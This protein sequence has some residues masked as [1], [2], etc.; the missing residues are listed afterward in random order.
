[1]GIRDDDRN[2]YYNSGFQDGYHKAM[3]R[4]REIVF[5]EYTV[6]DRYLKMDSESTREEDNCQS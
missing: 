6:P 4:I 5:A 1:M 3:D 2:F